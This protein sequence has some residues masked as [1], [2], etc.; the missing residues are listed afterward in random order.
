MRAWLALVLVL[1]ALG[2]GETPLDLQAYRAAADE[3]A[4]HLAEGRVSAADSLGHNVAARGWRQGTSVLVADPAF[5]VADDDTARRA[6]RLLDVAARLGALAPGAPPDRALLVSLLPPEQIGDAASDLPVPDLFTRIGKWVT[7]TVSDI[8]DW[9]A[10]QIR[11]LIEGL[12]R[13]G[14]SD[15][16]WDI[17]GLA[18]IGAIVL[19]AAGAAMIGVMLWRRSR[20]RLPPATAIEVPR[21]GE[22]AIDRP[23][24]EWERLA[25]ELAAR[26]R[27]REAIRAWFNAGL[28]TAFALG[29]LVHRRG[30]T[31]WEYVAQAP[32]QASWRMTMVGLVDTFEATWYGGRE[33]SADEAERF[34][35]ETASF[36]TQ[37]RAEPGA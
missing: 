28:A 4:A 34:R 3:V 1:G 26:G 13:G 2:A 6:R 9:I 32:P 17:T 18:V 37:V 20:Q 12:L 36:L 10:R 22:E 31:N 23:I 27:H 24:G 5:T 21:A 30:R 33:A 8:G 29:R 11:R 16:G 25:S 35:A 14:R 19:I 7:D 15:G